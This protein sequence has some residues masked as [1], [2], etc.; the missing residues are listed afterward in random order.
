MYVNTF[1]NEYNNLKW[2]LTGFMIVTLLLNVCARISG[3][4]RL[5][6]M[7]NQIPWWREVVEAVNKLAIGYIRRTRH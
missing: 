2:V 3:G 7:F 6:K 4:A 5:F 1:S